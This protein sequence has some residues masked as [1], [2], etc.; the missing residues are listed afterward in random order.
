MPESTT[1]NRHR[2]RDGEISK[3]HG[4]T[5][6]RTLRKSYG[7]DFASGCR[8]DETLSAVLHKMD[9]PSLGK[10]VQDHGRGRLAQICK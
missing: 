7:A 8:D 6:I 4:N 2:D 5:L 3:K 9:E 1:A 10:L